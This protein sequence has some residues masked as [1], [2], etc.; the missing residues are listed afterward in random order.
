MGNRA[1][2]K[3]EGKNIGIYLHCIGSDPDNINN[4]IFDKVRVL[5]EYL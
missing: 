5:H 4:Y 3:L 2:I 1:I